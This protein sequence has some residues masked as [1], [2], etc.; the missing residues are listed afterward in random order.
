MREE[1]EAS[2]DHPGRERRIVEADGTLSDEVSCPVLPD[3]QAFVSFGLEQARFGLVG[4]WII[5]GGLLDRGSNGR[6]RRS[7]E[8][9]G[10]RL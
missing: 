5:G 10:I 9:G 8:A 4:R 3:G 6:E 2:G 1:A 7:L